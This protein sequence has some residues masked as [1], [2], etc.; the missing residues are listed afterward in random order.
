[1]R[2]KVQPKPGAKGG[3]FR[4]GVWSNA[5]SFSP[6]ELHGTTVNADKA[7]AGYA[8]YDVGKPWQPDVG[9]KVH[10]GNAPW[11]PMK[12]NFNP[13]VEAVWLDCLEIIRVD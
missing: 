10:F 8:W 3:A 13:N 2:A 1:M 6:N 12:S 5:A 9:E 4:C 7:S 11:D